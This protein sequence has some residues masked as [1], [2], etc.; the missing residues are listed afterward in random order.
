MV[1]RWVKISKYK[2]KLHCTA[3]FETKMPGRSVQASIP[4]WRWR[5]PSLPQ[6]NKL[7]MKPNIGQN[8]L[9][10]NLSANPF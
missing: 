9:K 8:E 3:K 4:L 1:V 5:E 6:F 7:M 2:R 10:Y